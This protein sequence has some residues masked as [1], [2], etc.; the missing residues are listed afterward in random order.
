MALAG[1]SQAPGAIASS[2]PAGA[3]RELI[4]GFDMESMCQIL[5][6][7]PEFRAFASYLGEGNARRAW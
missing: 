7:A 1:I 5:D 4:D 2:V 6:A 3:L